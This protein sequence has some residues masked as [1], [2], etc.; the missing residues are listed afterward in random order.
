MTA[1]GKPTSAKARAAMEAGRAKR[2]AQRDARAKD[3]K[4]QA[5][6]TAGDKWAMLLSGTLT[7]KDMDDEEL[8]RC[9]FRSKD[10]SFVGAPRMIPSH[11]AAAITNERIRRVRNMFEEALPAAVQSL[12]DIASD[13]DIK[14]SD[15]IK[16][17]QII[18]ERVMGKA[19]QSLN[20]K[21][22]DSFGALLSAALD[23]DRDIEGSI[24]S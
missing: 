21:A 22:E 17:A 11:I 1:K 16:A 18:V 5:L 14:E 23:V 13:T 2:D 6:P 4:Y 24:D 8:K 15:R 3:A 7:V 10:G 20:L 12:V 9:K 19:E